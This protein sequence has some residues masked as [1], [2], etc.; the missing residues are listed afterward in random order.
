M[1]GRPHVHHRVVD[2]TNER[3]KE[4]AVAGSPHGTVV[5]AGEQTAGRGRQ[6]RSW[7]APPGRAL[8]MSLVLRD[9]DERFPLVPLAAAVAVTR[10]FPEADGIKWPNDV[11]VDGRKVAGILI[12]GRPRD[13]WAVLGIGLNVATEPGEFPEEL[14]ATA[15]SLRAAG[16]P[17]ATPADALAELLP[18]LGEWIAAPPGD[19]LRAWRERDALRG[20]TVSWADGSGTAAGV[21]DDGSLLVETDDGVQALHA[22]EVH[23]RRE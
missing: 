19:V 4:L 1:I 5:T 10:A 16:S 23:L 18:A 13:G 21:D 3:A 22:G 12:E 15:T 2:S 6:G 11:W 20:Q 17:L 8:L 7:V 9:L 14:R